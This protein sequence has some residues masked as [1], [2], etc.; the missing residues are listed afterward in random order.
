MR[1][2]MTAAALEAVWHEMHTPLLRF[3]A[4]RVS[5]P[6]DAEDVL[7]DVMVESTGTPARSG[8]SSRSGHGCIR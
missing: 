8:S 1:L 6:R 2:P 5:D 3:I 4:H 7:Q